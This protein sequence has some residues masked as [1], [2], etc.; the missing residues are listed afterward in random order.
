[1][2]SN[3]QTRNDNKRGSFSIILRLLI[4]IL[5]IILLLWNVRIEN[6]IQSLAQTSFSLLL[7][8]ITYQYASILL[9]S[10]NQYILFTA[11]LK[12]PYRTFLSAYFKAY[13]FG[14]LLPG[15]IGDASI[16]Y[17]LKS[18]GL[19]YSQTFSAYILDKFLTFILY[20][21]IL[22]I[23]LGDIM[24]YP[25]IIPLFI[26]IALGILV[27]IAFYSTLRVAKY[28]PSAWQEFRLMRFFH[29]L[30]SQLLFFA[31]HHPHLLLMNFLLTGLK[32]GLIMLCYHAMITSLGYS[33]SAWKVGLAALASGIVGY[34]PISIQGLGTVEAVALLNF[35]NLGV[36]P[37][38]VLA[39]Y[40]VLRTNTYVAACL[41]YAATFIAQN[42]WRH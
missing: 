9:G 30:S 24:G 8:A 15:Q 5:L 20:V 18:K 29:N 28:F 17:F 35:K 26:V 31:K 10:F 32:L 2:T 40:L 6:L 38:D 3:K 11:F 13:A 23:F 7:L 21:F 33:L 42:T 36:S 19:Y 4:G 39:C 25:L 16:A 12:L 41:A 22:L 27:P 1:M 14:L 34:I 37:P